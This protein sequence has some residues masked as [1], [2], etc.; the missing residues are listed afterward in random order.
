[1]DKAIPKPGDLVI[2]NLTGSFRHVKSVTVEASGFVTM[3]VDSE[4]FDGYRTINDITL[5]TSEAP[6][7]SDTS[8]KPF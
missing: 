8:N 3:V 5:F 1:M 7:V 2:D 6:P 4:L